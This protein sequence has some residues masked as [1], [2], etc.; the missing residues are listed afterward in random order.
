M[1][2]DVL[3]RWTACVMTREDAMSVVNKV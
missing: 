1:N 3:S 2:A